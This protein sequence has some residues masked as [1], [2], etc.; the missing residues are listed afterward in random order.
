MFLNLRVDVADEFFRKRKENRVNTPL[1][2]VKMERPA[3]RIRHHLLQNGG[4][5][6][7][8]VRQLAES[9]LS[10]GSLADIQVRVTGFSLWTAFS[11]QNKQ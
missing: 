5:G 7:A 9:V 3:S 11:R 10:V 8:G 1:I 6:G 4:L 2:P